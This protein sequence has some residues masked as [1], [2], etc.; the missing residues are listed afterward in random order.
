MR[1]RYGIRSPRR[2]TGPRYLFGGHFPLPPPKPPKAPPPKA[3]NP[4]IPARTPG[5]APSGPGS[6]AALAGKTGQAAP[7]PAGWHNTSIGPRPGPSPATSPARHLI[8]EAIDYLTP[9]P[10]AHEI[11]EA[12]H[13]LGVRPKEEQ[14]SAGGI[15]KDTVSA[16]GQELERGL[17][18]LAQDAAVAHHLPQALQR[19]QLDRKTLGSPTPAQVIKAGREGSL[20]LNRRGKLT[21]PATRHAARQLKAAR[22]QYRQSGRLTGPLTEGQRIFAEQVGRET[23]LDPRVIAAQALAEESG[24]AAQKREA[25][26][27]HNWLNIAYFDSGPGAATKSPVWSTPES[28]ARATSEFLKG[29]KFGASEGI[30][31]IVKTAG[32]SPQAQL[33]AIVNSGW[34]SSGYGGSLAGT[35]SQIGRTPPNPQAVTDLKAAK[36]QAAQLG[37]PT[38]AGDV[39]QGPTAETVWVRA[40]AKGMVGWAKALLGTQGGTPKQLSWAN[41]FGLSAS[42]PWCANFVSAG[43]ARRGVKLPPN[44]NY[45]PSYEG[46][47]TGGTNIGT[48]LSKA[49]P[50]DLIA[51]SGE[52]I[53]VYIGNGEII[54]GNY[55]NAV[56]RSPVNYGGPP[57]SAIL[58]PHYR[59]GKV[60]VAVGQALPGAA[61]GPSGEVVSG[62]AGIEGASTAPPTAAQEEQGR[63]AP[64]RRVVSSALPALSPLLAT[65]APLPAAYLQY[66]GGGASPIPEELGGVIEQILKRRRT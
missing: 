30:R 35:Y 32:Q 9:G 6:K 20:R 42:Q 48:D 3:D 29:Q 59:G 52:H 41:E 25:E 26:G 46:A 8:Q 2:L 53:G 64:T 7:R 14:P 56:T 38:K 28:A 51:F 47:W 21:I 45:V 61:I 31:N 1:P 36:H 44:P 50:G 39:E 63:S 62:P 37:I 65:G 49:K 15:L 34:A 22:Q 33:A 55:S 11:A 5:P 12:A 4:N 18:V 19:Q 23:G 43:L 13:R 57:I 17:K 27:N 10:T 60:K 54:S 16:A 58:R 24:S 66:H 40:D